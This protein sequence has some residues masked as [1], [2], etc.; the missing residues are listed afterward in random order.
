MDLFH[1]QEEAAGARV[2]ASEGLDAVPH[3]RRLHARAAGARPAISEVKTPQLIDR[4]LWEASG[5]W[6]KF[7]ENMFT[8]EDRATSRSSRSSR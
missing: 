2:L 5:H 7:G 6:E 3:A 8:T 4:S 1:L